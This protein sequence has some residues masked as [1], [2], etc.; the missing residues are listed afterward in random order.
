MRYNF[1]DWCG[2]GFFRKSKI[3]FFKNGPA[4]LPVKSYKVD[5]VNQ[6]IQNAWAKFVAIDQNVVE[7]APVFHN[8]YTE[9]EIKAIRERANKF[10]K[11]SF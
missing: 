7:R 6:S 4:T 2:S 8:R 10:E 1:Y 5:I 9:E 11:G 3:F